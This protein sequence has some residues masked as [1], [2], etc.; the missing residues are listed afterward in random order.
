MIRYQVGFFKICLEI[1]YVCSG[2]FNSTTKT[3]YHFMDCDT[4]RHAHP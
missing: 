2:S 4:Y 1:I 3:W